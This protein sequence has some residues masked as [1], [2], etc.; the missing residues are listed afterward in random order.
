[1]DFPS[2]FYRLRAAESQFRAYVSAIV[3]P[4]IRRIFNSE[5]CFKGPHRSTLIGPQKRFFRTFYD[6]WSVQVP[7]GTFS[8]PSRH[9]RRLQSMLLPFGNVLARSNSKLIAWIFSIIRIAEEPRKRVSTRGENEGHDRMAN[10]VR[11]SGKEAA[12]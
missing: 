8:G 7:I 2:T 5:L 11:T 6:E 10:C 12:R 1:M 3:T 4:H 9:I